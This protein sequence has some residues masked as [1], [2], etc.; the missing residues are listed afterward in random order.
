MTVRMTYL[1]AENMV[2][3]T[4]R[5]NLRVPSELLDL[6]EEISTRKGSGT[7]SDVVRDALERY[8]DDEADTWN[9]EIVK[10]KVPSGTMDAVEILVMAGDATDVTQA[11]NFALNDWVKAKSDY[12][13]EGKD[14]LRK[15][16]GEAVDERAMKERMKSVQ[17]R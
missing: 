3:K 6:L 16:V 5:L 11:I 1:R 2:A 14:A 15:K 9:S 8:A 7:L 12:H 13:L 4:S 10:A 17:R